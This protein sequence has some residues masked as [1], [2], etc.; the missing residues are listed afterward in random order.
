MLRAEGVCYLV[1][2]W[3]SLLNIL[4]NERVAQAQVHPEVQRLAPQESQ[5]FCRGNAAIAIVTAWLC[6]SVMPGG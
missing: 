3:L 4:H 6:V 2:G 5:F 1:H